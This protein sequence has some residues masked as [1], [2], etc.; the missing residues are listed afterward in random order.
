LNQLDSFKRDGKFQFRINWPG[1]TKRNIW[2]QT[3]NPTEDVNVAGYQDLSVDSTSNYW[4]GLEFGNGSHGPTNSNS[5]YIDGSVNH[6]NWFYAIGS[7]IQW[8]NGIPAAAAVA[9]S[10]QTVELWVK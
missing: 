9:D 2:S 1:F 8:G 3:S 7:Y 6:T 5:S 4:G 10:V